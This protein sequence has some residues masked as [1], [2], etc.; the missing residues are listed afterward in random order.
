M[1]LN[2]MI[3][4]CMMSLLLHCQTVN[5]WLQLSVIFMASVSIMYELLPIIFW[6]MDLITRCYCNA[7]DVHKSRDYVG[8]VFLS[9]NG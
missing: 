2:T 1:W 8:L 6:F 4:Q 7:K 5:L 3:L 9:D